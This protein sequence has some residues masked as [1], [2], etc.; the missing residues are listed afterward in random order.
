[1][2]FSYFFLR[3][4]FEVIPAMLKIQARSRATVPRQPANVFLHCKNMLEA[5]NDENLIAFSE[6]KV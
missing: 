1:M 6:G 5:R 3:F 2:F 4:P